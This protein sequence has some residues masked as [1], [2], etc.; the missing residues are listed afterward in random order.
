M[1]K[2][3]FGLLAVVVLFV[4]GLLGYW[5]VSTIQS[6]S[7][8]QTRQKFEQLTK[9]NDDLK[10]QVAA[11]TDQID[12]LQSQ[13]P[14]NTTDTSSGSGDQADKPAPTTTTYKY[15]SSI[16]DLQ[17]LE[18]GNVLMKIKS[19]GANVG[20]VQ[21]FLNIYNNTSNKIDNDFGPSM[22]KAIIAFQKD[23]GITSDGQVGPGTYSKMIDWLKKQG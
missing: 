7:E 10:I 3:K 19:S 16:N 2:M 23:Q 14:D 20:I 18:D 6:G 11:L 1:E 12:T 8:Y 17:K 5:A 22:E 15:Q 21:K 9:E 13:L 4:L